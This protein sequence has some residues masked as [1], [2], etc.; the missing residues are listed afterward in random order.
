ML[1]CNFLSTALNHFFSNRI[2]LFVSGFTH[3]YYLEIISNNAFGNMYHNAR[4]QFP[5]LNKMALEKVQSKLNVSFMGEEP[6]LS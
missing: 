4:S 5:F 3:Q 1:L 6:Q 2:L